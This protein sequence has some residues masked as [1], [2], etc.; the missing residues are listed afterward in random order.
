M[1]R[2]ADVCTFLAVSLG[3]PTLIDSNAA[4]KQRLH[5]LDKGDV[6]L[7]HDVADVTVFHVALRAAADGAPEALAEGQVVKEAVNC[8][9][10]LA[11]LLT[12]APSP[13]QNA[14]SPSMPAMLDLW[15]DVST[16]A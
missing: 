4:R 6:E 14:R 12:Y 1:L 7:V 9:G 10:G 3:P 15:T 8:G 11:L 16:T 2:N 13:C 5:V